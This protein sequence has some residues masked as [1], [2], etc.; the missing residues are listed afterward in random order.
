[1]STKNLAR[2]AI[3]GGRANTDDRNASHRNE[4]ARTR[5]WLDRVRFD[6]EHA[7]ATMPRRRP[8]VRKE[9][10]DKLEPCWGWLAS[11][12]GRPWDDVYG[13]LTSRFDTRK[14][15][16]K[17]IVF[18]HMLAE[19][20]GAGSAAGGGAPTWWRTTRFYVDEAGIL[21]VRDRAAA[22]KAEADARRAAAEARLRASPAHAAAV[23]YAAGRRVRADGFGY[24][25]VPGPA[26]WT[27]CRWCDARHA[28]HRRIETTPGYLVERYAS[29]GFKALGVGG[30]WRTYQ[31]EHF[32]PSWK[33][34][35]FSRADE[36]W[37]RA[38][39]EV[40]RYQFT[41]YGGPWT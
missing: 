41:V 2:T 35:T 16:N 5:A 3:E 8:S 33:C 21:R 40:I 19:V 13:E 27:P 1:M 7:N 39:P 29:A 10:S 38:L 23:A 30:W 11:R 12:A 18:D 31:P 20:D 37:W 24:W 26:V 34:V 25:C 28:P 14:L 36:A 4:R 15:S 9:F 6:A 22:V 17:H 32:V